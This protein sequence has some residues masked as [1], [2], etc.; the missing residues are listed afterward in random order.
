MTGPYGYTQAKALVFSEN[1]EPSNVLQWLPSGTVLL[2]TLAA[3]INPAD[4]NMIQGTYGS[5]L[6]FTTLL[7]TS[8]P[9]AIPG[10][11]GVFEILAI[12]SSTSH[13]Q[14]GD[15][16]VPAASQFVAT[17]SINPCTAYR[18]LRS[19]GPNAGIQNGLGMRPLDVGSGAIFIQNGAN[20]GVG[21]AAIQ[22]GKLW[23]LRSINIIRDRES[24]EETEA[25]VKE[26][27]DLGAW[28]D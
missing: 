21:R 13:L 17:V 6:A 10:S 1:G 22:F 2:R 8:E 24:P 7:G 25:L 12:S 11:E 28:E 26:L 27:K 18:I 3:P 16:V 9:S 4:I 14:K 20:S 5:K 19:Y 23:G 15:W